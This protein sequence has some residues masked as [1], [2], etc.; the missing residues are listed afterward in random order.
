MRSPEFSFSGFETKRL[1]RNRNLH[2]EAA[3]MNDAFRF[4]QQID[5]EVLTAS[6]GEYAVTLNSEWI[7]ED[8]KSFSFVVKGVE[9]KSDVIVLK[10]IVAFGD[11]SANFVRLVSRLERNIEKLWI[12]AE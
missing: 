12:E 5:A 8:F 2:V 10:N 9:K 7:E 11:S 3:L 6:F 1:E 4:H